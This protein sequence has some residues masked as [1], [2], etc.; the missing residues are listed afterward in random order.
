MARPC[1]ICQ[2]Q[3]VAAIDQALV[4][5]RPQRQVA[6]SFRVTH[7]AVQRHASTHVPDR[8]RE[9]ANRRSDTR[10]EA[11]I[12]RLA[13]LATEGEQVLEAA[14]ESGSDRLVLAALREV[15]ETLTTLTKVTQPKISDQ[16]VEGLIRALGTVLPRFPDTAAALARELQDLGSTDLAG[17]VAL[18]AGN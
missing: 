18:A 11:L 1:S 4:S 9:V 10:Y 3:D 16:E 5:G 15:R 12:A 17:V 14:K 6:E 8:M 2:S 7:S 13:A